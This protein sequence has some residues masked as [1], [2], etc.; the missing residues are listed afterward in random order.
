[1]GSGLSEMPNKLFLVFIFFSLFCIS[2][3][4][5]D[6]SDEQL[7]GRKFLDDFFW[8][9]KYLPLDSISELHTLRNTLIFLDE[10]DSE[11]FEKSNETLK[12]NIQD[13]HKIFLD[14][15]Y[16]RIVQT[17]KKIETLLNEYG[18]NTEVQE[19]A[20]EYIDFKYAVEN[21]NYPQD[22]I[23]LDRIDELYSRLIIGLGY[24]KL[25]KNNNGS[26]STGLGDDRINSG[27]NSNGKIYIVKNG[28]YLRKLA[29]IFYDNERYWR[30]I[31]NHN[32][33]QGLLGANPDLIYP[34]VTIEIPTLLER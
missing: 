11:G 22:D 23:C 2:V 24:K 16:Q 34:G 31:F 13:L 21:G 25:D 6:M 27:I 5:Q 26:I 33:K 20:I 7:D 4:P 18:S 30:L 8:Y 15:L 14:K 17:D 10:N 29:A 9:Q 1:L 12:V 28:D 19:A 3:Y 32:R